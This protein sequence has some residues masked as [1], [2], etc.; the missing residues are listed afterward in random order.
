MVRVLVL[1]ALLAVAGCAR[2]SAGSSPD[3][4]GSWQFVAGSSG[5][6][7][8]PQPTGASATLVFEDTRL[9]G[10]SFC[11]HYAG[12][13]TLD[14]DALTIDG[15]GGT[16]MGCDPH[17]MAAE[18]AF[19]TALGAA[20]RAAREGDELVLTGA[21]LALRFTRQAPVPDRELV[22][23][24]WTLDTLVEGEVAS[25]VL[26]EATL[27][28]AEDGT[29][30]GSTGC[31]GVLGTWQIAGAVL[32]LDVTRDDIGCPGDVGRQDE[33]VL[34]VLDNGPRVAID[35]DRLTLTAADGNGLIY[36]AG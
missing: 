15:L 13:Y 10:I 6:A 30:T 17:V 12:G 20:D 14:G 7:A 29:A 19:L 21:D 33:H 25:S 31:R 9:R 23:T 24:S 8:L 1:V 26:G 28:L 35:G 22:G 5:G 3:V 27:R 16:E 36:R 18:T 4:L 2:T 32:T 34:A 11:N